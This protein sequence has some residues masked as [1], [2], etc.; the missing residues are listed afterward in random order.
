M[1]A[2]NGNLNE[3]LKNRLK[4]GVALGVTCAAAAFLILFLSGDNLTN[5]AVTAAP[6]VILVYF[7]LGCFF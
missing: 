7:L 1:D 5:G 2:K 3:Y 4:R 6:A